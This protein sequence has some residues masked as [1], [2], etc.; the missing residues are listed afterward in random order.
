[1]VFTRNILLTLILLPFCSLSR[2]TPTIYYRAVTQLDQE[3]FAQAHQRDNSATRA[4]SNAQLQ[5]SDGRCVFIDLLSG[6]FRANLLPVQVG[7][8]SGSGRS[9]DVITK[10]EHI[11]QDGQALLVNALSEG[12]ISHD[13][14]RTTNQVHVFSCGG[15]AD[16]SGTVSDSQMFAFN[17]S[18]QRI[19]LAPHNQPAS[20][21]TVNGDLVRIAD[22]QAG[23]ANQQFTLTNTAPETTESAAQS[24]PFTSLSSIPISS[25]PISATDLS[26]Y[27]P[28]SRV[29]SEIT[30]VVGTPAAET[31]SNSKSSVTSFFAST[32]ISIPT[33][34]PTSLI[35]VSRAGGILQP[36][37]V[38]ESHRF[39]ASATRAFTNV[40]IKTPSGQCLFIDPTAGDFRENLIPVQFTSCSG[41][42]NEKF[43]FIVSGKHNDQ[44]GNTLIASSLTNG[45]IG[46]DD[47]RA[48]EDQVIVFSCGGRAAG[49]GLTDSAQLVPFTG[50]TSFV[51]APVGGENE[52]CLVGGPMRLVG[53]ACDGSPDQVFTIEQ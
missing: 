51:W 48:P 14:R 19:T 37:A 30:S 47:R 32:I 11:L 34:N 52:T 6:D 21:L 45:C 27:T 40:S 35:P 22:C 44:P 12:C 43:D 26:S 10:G 8:C 20:C 15:R 18:S 50:G 49:E 28:T 24:S 5:T 9:W 7:V 4:F 36:S 3:A 13:P 25:P 1:M 39:D 46:F 31:E 29:V 17:S 2:A 33:V 16:G 38:A 41:S 42:P 23:N 53:A